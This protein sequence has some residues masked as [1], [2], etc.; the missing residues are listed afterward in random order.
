M[1]TTGNGTAAAGVTVHRS[2]KVRSFFTV[3]GATAKNS[4]PVQVISEF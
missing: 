2:A 1:Q 4:S 3:K